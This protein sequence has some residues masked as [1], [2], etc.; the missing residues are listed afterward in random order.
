[1][2]K[3]SKNI[4]DRPLYRTLTGVNKAGK[5]IHGVLDVVPL[6]NIHEIV[7]K[8]IK[9]NPNQSVAEISK[10]VLKKIDWVRTLIALIVAAGII[11]GWFTADQIQTIIDLIQQFI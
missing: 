7:K 11:K 2:K 3:Q 5:I 8:S 1:M 10:D 4:K 6:P 9:T